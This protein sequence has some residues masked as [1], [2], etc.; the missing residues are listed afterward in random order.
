M[1]RR[2]SLAALLIALTGLAVGLT[3]SFRSSAPGPGVARPLTSS[4]RAGE[5]EVSVPRGFSHYT[6]T[7]CCG[8]VTGQVLTDIRLPAHLNIWRAL[9]HQ[10]R[11]FLRGRRGAED[12]EKPRG[13]LYRCLL[14]LSFAE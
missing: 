14:R 8:L 2:R 6:L 10:E 1:R 11:I 7:G 13:P 9:D 5:V 4:V 3:L 12:A